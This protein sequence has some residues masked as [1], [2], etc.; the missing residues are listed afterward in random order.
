MEQVDIVIVGAGFSGLGMAIQL[1]RHGRRDFALVEQSPD[2]GGTWFE[3]RY[4]GCACDVPSSALFLLVR[5]EPSLEPRLRATRRDLALSRPLRRAL[6]TPSAPPAGAAGDRRPFRRDERTLAGRA[7]RRARPRCR[8]LVMGVGALHQP[9][10]PDIEGLD[11]LRWRGVPLQPLARGVHAGRQA[12]R[13]HRHRRERDPD[14][15]GACARRRAPRRVPADPRLD[16]AE[17]R[18]R[19]CPTAHSGSSSACRARSRAVR[20]LIYWH[21]RGAW[22]A[23][24]ALAALGQPARH[25]M[26]AA[27]STPG[28]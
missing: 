26:P 12:G 7:R 16:H 1:A 10:I 28:R 15:A 2:L 17:T 24:P 5:A 3:N 14:R 4:P 6:C 9:R 25:G 23:V 18:T 21:A 11:R 8:V 22:R 19:R 13:R 20:G 27:T